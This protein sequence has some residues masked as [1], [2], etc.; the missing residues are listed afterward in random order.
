MPSLN[1]L[2]C[3]VELTPSNVTLTEHGTRYGD[4]EV[5]TYIAVPS[6]RKSKPLTF[7]LHLRATGYIGPG[8]AMFVY[9]DGLY[10]CNRHRTSLRPDGRC[11]MNFRVRQEERQTNSG[12]LFI[13]RDWSFARLDVSKYQTFH[14]TLTPSLP[15][16]NRCRRQCR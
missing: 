5:E 7:S 1:N 12:E 2:T 8:L 4:G 13:G 10:Q 3:T 14:S 9:I 15:T 16:S 6:I 11:E